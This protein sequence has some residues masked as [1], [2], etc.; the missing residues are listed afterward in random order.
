VVLYELLVGSRPYRIKTE[1]SQVP[2]ERAINA[3]HIRKPSTQVQ[4]PAA[5]VRATTHE[6]LARRLRA[7]WMRSCSGPGKRPRPLPSATAFADDLQRYL[8]GRCGGGTAGPA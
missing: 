5:A 2:L 1:A 6:Q 7:T 8:S 3:A 4:A